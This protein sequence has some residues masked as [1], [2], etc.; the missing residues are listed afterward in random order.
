MEVKSESEVAPSC[1]SLRNP[2]DCSPPGSSIHGIFQARVVEWDTIAFSVFSLE[3]ENWGSREIFK[4]SISHTFSYSF[5]K[6]GF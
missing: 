1:P 5:L 2:M 6:A 3:K 4:K